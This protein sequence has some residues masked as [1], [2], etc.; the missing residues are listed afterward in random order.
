M[1]AAPA[2]RRGWCPGALRPMETGDGWLV[3]VR[4]RAGRLSLDAL[5]CIGMAA[6]RHGNGLVDLSSRGN[7]QIRGVAPDGHGPLL[8]LLGE[9]GLLDPNIRAEGVRNVVVSPVSDIDPEGTDP[10]PLAN[11][12][13]E[14]LV[15]DPALSAL[16]GKFCFVVDG[17]GVLHLD[18]LTADIRLSLSADGRTVAV[19]G[20]GL[21]LGLCDAGDGV[22]AAMRLARAA[23]AFGPA[24]LADLV[25]D[26]G[27]ER[28]QRA[29]AP[30]VRSGAAF[31]RRAPA[32]V[33]AGPV[34]DLPALGLGLPFGRIDAGGIV[35]LVALARSAGLGELRLSPWRIL[36]LGPLDGGSMARLVREAAEIGLVADPADPLMRIAACP[37]APACARATTDT[38][39]DARAIAAAAPALLDGSLGMHVS[40]CA[41]GCARPGASG[42]VLVADGKGAYGL[43][44]EGRP[45][46]DP[47]TSLDPGDLSAAL[48]RLAVRAGIGTSAE[49]D[50]RA[51]LRRLGREGIEAALRNGEGGGDGP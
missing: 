47:V 37:G 41:K 34:Q 1:S 32:R 15:A 39:R 8:A 24:R 44:H 31:G 49:G 20:G 12:L 6:R 3:R 2:L 42:L 33:H 50:A 35:R 18:G 21:T 51:A 46:G 11:A 28:F 30:L 9:A 25:R 13:E 22:D 19:D 38:R 48:S 26:M 27:I 40:G 4:P 43:V 45:D 7:F 29:L 14:A 5:A 10:V 16:P 17:G 36:F 23:V